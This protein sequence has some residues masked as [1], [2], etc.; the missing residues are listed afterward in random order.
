MQQYLD[1]LVGIFRQ[2]A[3]VLVSEGTIWLNHYL[4]TGFE[5]FTGVGQ[6]GYVAEKTEG[7]RG[8]LFPIAQEVAQIGPGEILPSRVTC[9]APPAGQS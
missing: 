4:R 5:M 6:Q 2:V 8:W 3:R 9:L 7:D 1:T